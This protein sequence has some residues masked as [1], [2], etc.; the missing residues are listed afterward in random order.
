[1]SP[2]KRR[3]VRPYHQHH[4]RWCC[5]R[6]ADSCNKSQHSH[7]HNSKTIAA[8]PIETKCSVPGTSQDATA[9]N[10]VIVPIR[11]YEDRT[12]SNKKD[13]SKS[14]RERK[15]GEHRE[16]PPDGVSE[17]KNRPTNQ[18]TDRSA[19]RPAGRPTAKRKKWE[20]CTLLTLMLPFASSAF[21]CFRNSNR[22]R[23]LH[24]TSIDDPYVGASTGGS[25]SERRRQRANRT[26]NI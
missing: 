3:V 13:N 1:M 5:H 23:V 8:V 19:L 14:Q 21:G 7:R 18:P 11:P 24:G 12:R 20:S 26:S 17:L 22:W 2:A 10:A 6:S 4:C 15:E 25:Y 9:R 16:R